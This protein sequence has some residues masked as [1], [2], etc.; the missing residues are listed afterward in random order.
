MTKLTVALTILPCL[1][2]QSPNFSGVWELDNTQSKTARQL[3]ERVRCKIDQQGD[4][5]A[6]TMRVA[7][8]RELQQ[9]TLRY[10]ASQETRNE[11]SGAP[12]TSR[13]E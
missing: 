7:S 1:C 5:I 11:M 6:M 9:T 2:A 13:A 3:S 8:G 4:A 10:V 12:V